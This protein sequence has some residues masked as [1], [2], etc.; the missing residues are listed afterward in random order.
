MS[1]APVRPDWLAVGE[2]LEI[3]RG[4]TG[5][6]QRDFCQPAGISESHYTGVKKGHKALGFDKAKKLKE[7]YGISLDW[8]FFGDLGMETKMALT[9]KAVQEQRNSAEK[10]AAKESP[11]PAAHRTRAR[12]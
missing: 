5:L 1:K 9:L 10:P 11:K 12:G 8:I 3:A 7:I 4:V 2:R 6:S